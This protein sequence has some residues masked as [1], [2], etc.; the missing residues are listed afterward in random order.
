MWIVA[1]LLDSAGLGHLSVSI[2]AVQ[3]FT[4]FD[5]GLNNGRR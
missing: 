2:C 3:S 4:C 1:T 5:T